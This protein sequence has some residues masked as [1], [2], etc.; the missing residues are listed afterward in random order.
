MDLAP[1]STEEGVRAWLRDVLDKLWSLN[2]ATD[3][4]RTGGA[5]LGAVRKAITARGYWPAVGGEPMSL[6]VLQTIHAEL[7]YAQCHVEHEAALAAQV[8]A[9]V[10][11][12][13]GAYRVVDN[14]AVA[15]DDPGTGD[16]LSFPQTRLAG[17]RLS[18]LKRLVVDADEASQYIVGARRADGALCLAVVDADAPGTAR[19]RMR[20]IANRPFWS[21][22]FDDVPVTAR[23][24]VGRS[25]LVN[26]VLPVA[27]CLAASAA[28][29]STRILELTKEYAQRREAFGRPISSFQVIQHY[30][31]DAA[32]RA[33]AAATMVRIAAW[34]LDHGTSDAAHA[35]ATA[36]VYN[37]AALT[38][39]A[40]IGIQVHGGIG[41]VDESGVPNFFRSATV[42]RHAWGDRQFWLAEIARGLESRK[43]GAF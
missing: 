34:K 26:A 10:V 40:N 28:G 19:R 14:I 27:L 4:T 23:A 17:S 42:N 25:V 9:G 20:S 1:S 8:F 32:I 30:L 11:A 21:V 41:F 6:E 35:V 7:G 18:G 29:G 5:D 22:T 33:K 12:E 31:A 37:A 15:L 38:E 3:L 36:K 16:P 24:V 13:H 43:A 2:A 39:L